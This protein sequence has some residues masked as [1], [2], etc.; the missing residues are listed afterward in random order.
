MSS[1]AQTL[2]DNPGLQKEVRQFWKNKVALPVWILS[3]ILVIGGLLFA[4]HEATR[5]GHYD[6]NYARYQIV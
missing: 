2:K 5:F 1:A 4:C 6:V 3:A